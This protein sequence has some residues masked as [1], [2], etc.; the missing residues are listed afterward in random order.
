VRRRHG[1]A[2]GS[3]LVNFWRF[4]CCRKFPDLTSYY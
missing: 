2:G 4:F 3:S 1:E